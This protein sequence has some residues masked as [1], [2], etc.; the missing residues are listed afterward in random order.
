[1]DKEKIQ[2]A[3]RQILEAI[4]EDPDRQGLLDTPKRV[5]NMYEEVFSGLSK[6]PAIHCETVFEEQHEEMVLVKDIP[7]SS[8]CEHHL[9]PFIGTA[10]V[11]YI[12][13][14]GRVIGLSKMARIVDD[15]SKRPQLQER[16]TKSVAD[17]LMEELDPVGVMVILEA[18]HMCMSIRG[19]KKQG[20]KTVTS[21]VRGS[22]RENSKSRN[23]VLAL[24]SK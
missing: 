12:P 17:L 5:A 7:F 4:G 19:V 22:F 10:H 20:S 23:E 6:N 16:I 15:I 13:K 2:L 14:N 3:V 9:V 24:I 11:A 21:A 1:M 8:M 18:E